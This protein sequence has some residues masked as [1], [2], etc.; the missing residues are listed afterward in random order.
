MGD[1]KV[2]PQHLLLSIPHDHNNEAK[3]YLTGHGITLEKIERRIKAIPNAQDVFEP[4]DG[5][6]MSPDEVNNKTIFNKPE[7]KRS[8]TDTP[9]MDS[10]S[11]DLTVK[12][13]NGGLDPVVGREDEMLR[14]AQILCRR[15]K[16]NPILIGQPGVGKSAVVEGLAQMIVKHQVPYTLQN[17]RILSLNMASIV[18]GTQFRGQFEN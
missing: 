13:E 14:I 17:K 1:S 5:E 7:R 12:A 9:V 2:K 10:F 18:A 8:N 11:I 16:N 6:L 15:K 4:V 3:I